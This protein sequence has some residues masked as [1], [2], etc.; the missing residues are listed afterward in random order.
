MATKMHLYIV[1]VFILCDISMELQAKNDGRDCKVRKAPRP[2]KYVDCQ[3][4]E[5]TIQHGR[6][7]AANSSA[8]FGYYCWNGTVTPLECR[9]SIPRS[10]AEYKYKRQQDPWPLCCYWV[11][12]CA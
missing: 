12:T 5:T 3:L 4:G 1:L 10:T 2:K 8:C 7:R 9:T 11:R 6:T